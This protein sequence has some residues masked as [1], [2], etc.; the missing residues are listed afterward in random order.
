MMYALHHPQTTHPEDAR[1]RPMRAAARTR[2]VFE[3][4][5]CWREEGGEE[6]TK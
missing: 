5:V 4:G 2:M 1:A 3:C 6:G